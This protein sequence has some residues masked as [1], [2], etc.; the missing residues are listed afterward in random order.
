MATS[1]EP[2]GRIYHWQPV[3]IGLTS[4]ARDPQFGGNPADVPTAFISL[5]GQI[6]VDIRIATPIHWD[7]ERYRFRR[8]T[9][10]PAISFWH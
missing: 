2:D 8:R 9:P 6:L 7:L 5:A 10:L 3:H 1:L 4:D